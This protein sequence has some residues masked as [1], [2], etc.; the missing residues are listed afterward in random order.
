MY[1]AKFSLEE[2]RGRGNTGGHVENGR[3]WI[4]PPERRTPVRPGA[5][6][7]QFLPIGRSAL[8]LPRFRAVVV[9]VSSCAC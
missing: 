8:R 7:C 3:I 4:P 5:H 9:V 1:S 2:P 6:G